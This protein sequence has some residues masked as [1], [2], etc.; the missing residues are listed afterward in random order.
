M[1]S[2]Y[3]LIEIEI[4]NKNKNIGNKNIENEYESGQSLG[5]ENLE[6]ADPGPTLGIL[7]EALLECV[8]FGRK[9]VYELGSAMCG[10]I[11]REINIMEEKH[12]NEGKEADERNRG[13]GRR[14]NNLKE[15]RNGFGDNY[16]QPN[17]ST[18]L[19]PTLSTFSQSLLT[20]IESK[21]NQKDGIDAIASCLCA[22]SRP[23]P[24]FLKKPMFL[25]IMSTFRRLKSRGRY[26][27]L[28]AVYNSTGIFPNEEGSVGVEG[29]GVGGSNSNSDSNSNSVSGAS[30]S[31]SNSGYSSQRTMGVIDH[32]NPFLP[33]LLADLSTVVIRLDNKFNS[34]F[35]S[36]SSRT[37]DTT[38]PKTRLPMVQLL[39]VKL[40]TR[41]ADT[42]DINIIDK[43]VHIQSGNEM[44]ESGASEGFG[45]ELVLNSKAV[46]E[47]HTL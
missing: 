43:L 2:G 30:G 13:S 44:E 3:P 41:Y 24:E 4:K 47:V 14:E 28:L 29:G 18:C 6:S 12:K 26:E 45:L 5:Y 36:Y 31:G 21:F 7:L 32:L 40:L 42:L 46:L 17:L 39:T 10:Q 37:T 27:F 34:P 33:A 11:I 19:T 20:K 22:V 9:E 25:R 35:S 8:K 15:N 23:C 1:E 16:H 38:I